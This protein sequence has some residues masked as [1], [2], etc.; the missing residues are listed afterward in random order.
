M[1]QAGEV[2]G[3]IFDGNIQSLP[4]NFAYTDAMGRAVSADARGIQEALRHIYGAAGLADELLK[5][6][7]LRHRPEAEAIKPHG[8]TIVTGCPLLITLLAMWKSPSHGLF[9]ARGP[10]STV[11]EV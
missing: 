9:H 7:R 11:P 5:A 3:I 2:V 10:A 1:N 6:A 8:Q 4:W